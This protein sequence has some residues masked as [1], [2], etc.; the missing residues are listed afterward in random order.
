MYEAIKGI[1]QEKGPTRVI[2]ETGGLSYRVA[3]P[4]RSFASLP[5][6]Q[7]SVHLF[8]SHVVR[9]DAQALYG[10]LTKEERD[11]F[12]QL[13]Q[14]SG[15]G[16]KTALTIL[17]HIDV[18]SLALAVEKKEAKRLY[19]LPGIGKKTAE[20]LILE[21]QG[22]NLPVGTPQASLPSLLQDGVSALVHLGYPVAKAEKIFENL[23]REHEK[24]TDLSRL[25]SLALQKI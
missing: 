5:P 6:L 20:R 2:V 25:L 14:I 1:L 17:G 4:L 16:P 13:T 21:L 8:L 19:S 3:I 11:L 24:E 23:L 18:A 9:E 22:K 12:E 7:D 10:F 15:I